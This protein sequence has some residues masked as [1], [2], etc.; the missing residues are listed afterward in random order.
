MCHFTLG[1]CMRHC[2]LWNSCPVTKSVWLSGL[3]ERMGICNYLKTLGEA[4]GFLFFF[5]SSHPHPSSC[6]THT[7][8]HTPVCVSCQ[9]SSHLKCL[10]TLHIKGRI[11]Y[12]P[13][14]YTLTIST[15]HLSM[16]WVFPQAFLLHLLKV[17]DTMLGMWEKAKC[18]IHGN[19]PSNNIHQLHLKYTF[20]WKG[21]YPWLSPL[22]L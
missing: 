11:F 18:V 1:Q 9:G 15:L 17:P 7:H 13:I 3:E 19:S 6:T 5:L 4:Q 10:L 21:I 12:I 16:Q 22:Q 14:S 20:D 2:L 8:T